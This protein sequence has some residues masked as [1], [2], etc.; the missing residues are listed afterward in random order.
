M[1]LDE[2]KA[3]A[4]EEVEKLLS[5]GRNPQL[6]RGEVIGM[7]KMYRMLGFVKDERAYD[8]AVMSVLEEI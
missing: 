4:L 8:D 5:R 6:I 3:K 7:F 2:L 1:T